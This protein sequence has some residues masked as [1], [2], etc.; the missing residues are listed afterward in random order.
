MP[1]LAARCQAPV[2]NEK[3]LIANETFWLAGHKPQCCRAS[4]SSG[5]LFAIVI[6]NT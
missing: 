1:A 2:P 3:F 6:K 4:S 5:C